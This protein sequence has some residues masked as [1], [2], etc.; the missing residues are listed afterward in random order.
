[1]RYRVD[2]DNGS[3]YASYDASEYDRAYALYKER[4]IRL[5]Q[6][7]DIH[8]EGVVIEGSPIL[9]DITREPWNEN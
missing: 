4:G 6:C 1:M 7:K 8:D 3:G 5:R 2:F 9:E